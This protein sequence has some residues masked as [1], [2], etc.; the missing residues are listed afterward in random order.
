MKKL[1]ALIE[2]FRLNQVKEA[3]ADLGITAMTVT[4][5]RGLARHQEHSEIYRGSEYVVDLLPKIKLELVLEEHEVEDAVTA[6]VR[7]SKKNGVEAGKVFV[8]GIDEATVVQT[9]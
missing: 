4:E 3:L 2:P 8:S 7:L 9:D 1:E 6:I 5:V